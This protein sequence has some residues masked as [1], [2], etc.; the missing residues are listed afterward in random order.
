[1]KARGG[2]NA[3]TTHEGRVAR[4]C[5]PDYDKRMIKLTGHHSFT[6]AAAV[7]D[8]ATGTVSFD[9]DRFLA[10]YLNY[11]SPESEKK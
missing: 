7:I 2:F 1:M 10:Q 11:P 6:R 8:P 3:E 9:V 4:A 5:D